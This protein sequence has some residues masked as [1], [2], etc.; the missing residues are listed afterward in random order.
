MRERAGGIHDS[1]SLRAM[2]DPRLLRIEPEMVRRGLARRGENPGEIDRA[3]E[4][5]AEVRA[6]QGA[7]DEERAAINALSKQ[8]G[9]LHRDGRGDE[10]EPLQQASR[11]HGAR[12]TELDLAA[13]EASQELR[14]ILLRLP[15]L[16]A[17]DCPDGESEDDNVVLRVEG[18]DPEAYGPH[19]RVP[20]WESAVELGLLDVERAAKLSGSMFV[21][22]RGLGARLVRALVQLA[23]DRNQDLYEGKPV[24]T[25]PLISHLPCLLFP[26]S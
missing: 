22:Y 25:M 20:H 10:A 3:I 11:D 23:L 12:E 26:L 21:L 7:R 15:N 13:T 16:P 8:I 1:G 19:Q 9:A 5:D 2:L 14:A 24:C 4:L 18:F 6:L 17:D